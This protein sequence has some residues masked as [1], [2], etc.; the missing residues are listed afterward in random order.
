MQTIVPAVAQEVAATGI[1]VTYPKVFL[2]PGEPFECAGNVAD[3]YF[4]F[5]NGRVYR[6][7]LCEDYPIHSLAFEKDALRT[8]PGI[9]EADLF[10][11]DIPEGCAAY[12]QAGKGEPITGGQVRFRG[13]AAARLTEGVLRRPW[14]EFTA[15]PDEDLTNPGRVHLDAFGN[16]HTGLCPEK[17]CGY[18]LSSAL[19]MVFAANEM[20]YAGVDPNQIRFKRAGCFDVGLQCGGWGRVVLELRVEDRD[21]VG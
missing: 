16:L 13:R 1:T 21:G 12:P 20:L 4:I 11:L 19:M 17:V 8:R 9:N 6:C 18:S 5:P 10:R 15:C 2:D 3:N 14:T 7:P